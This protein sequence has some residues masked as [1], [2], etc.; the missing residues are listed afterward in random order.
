MNSS[1]AA[2]KMRAAVASLATAGMLSATVGTLPATADAQ[3][4]AN[5]SYTTRSVASVPQVGSAQQISLAMPA[6]KRS[7]KRVTKVS[8]NFRRGPSKS[9]RVIKV[10]RKGKVVTLLGR[11][12]NG[13]VK[14]KYSARRGW[15]A[16]RYLKKVS[17][18]SRPRTVALSGRSYPSVERRLTA[19]TV[20]V[21][22]ALRAAFPQIKTVYGYR[23]GS[24]GE[25]RLGR[26]LDVMLP[27][28]YRTASAR[29]LGKRIATWARSNADKLSVYY[30]I[31]DQR[32]WNTQRSGDGWRLMSNGGS[33]SANHKNHVHISVKR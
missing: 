17:S 27:G 1:S 10:I 19:K 31:W 14:V 13:Y 8:V 22:R 26:A 3:A 6:A 20:R 11:K 15:V 12:A 33:A 16:A 28:N 24:A 29:A 2:V 5:P 30:V 21:H 25:H 4:I 9:D 32:I 7:A 23:P 18:S